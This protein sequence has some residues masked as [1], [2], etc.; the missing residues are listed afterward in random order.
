MGL[1]RSLPTLLFGPCVQF[2][3]LN[4]LTVYKKKSGTLVR[5]FSFLLVS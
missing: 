1:V 3:L 4:A 2:F 5:L